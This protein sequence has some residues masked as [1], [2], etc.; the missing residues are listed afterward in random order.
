[1]A[2]S[3]A[4]RISEMQAI[5]KRLTDENAGLKLALSNAKVVGK[6]KTLQLTK[7]AQRQFYHDNKSKKSVISAVRERLKVANFL[8]DD[9]AMPPWSL[10]KEYTN[11]L[12]NKSDPNTKNEYIK[13]AE[14]HLIDKKAKKAQKAKTKRER[15]DDVDDDDEE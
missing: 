1:M 15:D 8:Q 11:E 5:I 10:I 3:M 2:P 9:D 6:A 14:A 12:Y 7:V 13:K 4:M